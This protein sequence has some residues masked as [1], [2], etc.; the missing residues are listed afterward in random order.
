MKSA[1]ALASEAT[2]LLGTL[3]DASLADRADAL[4]TQTTVAMGQRDFAAAKRYADAE[5][6][7]V[8]SSEADS[9]L[10]YAAVMMAVGASWGL[11]TYPE[12]EARFREALACALRVD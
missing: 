4:R 7:L 1:A 5:L 8:N 3:P 6:A 9:R 10:R 12:A 11:E 2:T